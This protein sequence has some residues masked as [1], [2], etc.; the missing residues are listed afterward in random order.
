[1]NKK[2][3]VIPVLI[4]ILFVS[5]ISGTIFY[6]NNILN[7]KESQ[8]SLF[9]SE[10]PNLNTQIANLKTQI[11][12][13]TSPNLVTTLTTQEIV[14]FSPEYPG[15][16]H[17]T[18]PYNFEQITGTVTNAGG[19]T[20]Y[21][22]MIHVVGYDLNG[23]LVSN[24]TIPLGSGYF[25]SNNETYAFGSISSQIGTLMSGQIANINENIIHEGAAYNWTVTAL[26]TNSP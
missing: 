18:I 4:V 22:T 20:A 6:Y 19:G 12:N 8:I 5:A 15:G 3:I 2:I 25:G 21:N 24:V 9:N 23:V 10:I 17:Y 14:K 26:W 7:E 16:P 1:M 13:L 11:T